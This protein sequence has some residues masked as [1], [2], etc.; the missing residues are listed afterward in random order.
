MMRW[1]TTDGTLRLTADFAILVTI[2]LGSSYLSMPSDTSDC[3]ACADMGPG[4]GASLRG[5]MKS[6]RLL[7]L[8]LSRKQLVRGYSVAT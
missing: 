7:E 3:W 5:M 8:S 2:D 4:G 1:Q 6:S